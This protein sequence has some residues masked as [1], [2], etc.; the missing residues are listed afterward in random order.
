MDYGYS[1][2]LH[3]HSGD[4]EVYLPWR[5]NSLE[6]VESG[7]GYLRQG[8][9]REKATEPSSWVR[10]RRKAEGRGCVTLTRDCHGFRWSRAFSADSTAHS[11]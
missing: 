8:W 10:R 6:E 11:H 9:A 2:T 1:Y 3:A 5:N 4:V 7:G